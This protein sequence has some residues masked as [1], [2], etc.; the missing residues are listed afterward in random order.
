MKGSS[1]QHSHRTYAIEAVQPQSTTRFTEP[2]TPFPLYLHSST[3]IFH[4]TK[5]NN[6]SSFLLPFCFFFLLATMGYFLSSLYILFTYFCLL[7]FLT[8]FIWMLKTLDQLFNLY[9]V[10]LLVSIIES[11][12]LKCMD[13]RSCCGVVSVW[14]LVRFMI[15]IKRK[16]IWVFK[17]LLFCLLNLKPLLSIP[18][19]WSPFSCIV[20]TF[21]SAFIFYF[22]LNN[23]EKY[24][25]IIVAFRYA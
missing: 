13:L 22:F 3:K 20:F 16:L 10:F 24:K 9:L 17:F 2:P 14:R 1:Q 18:R 11:R 15:V 6:H 21:G 4:K 7:W 19:K 23:K 5:K 12:K 25:I 8:Y